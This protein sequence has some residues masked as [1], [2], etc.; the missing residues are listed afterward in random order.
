MIFCFVLFFGSVYFIK[1]I[2]SILGCRLKNLHTVETGVGVVCSH[3]SLG[4]VRVPGGPHLHAKEGRPAHRVDHDD[5]QGH[6]HSLW[7]G[8][9]HLSTLGGLRWAHG[10]GSRG[11]SRVRWQDWNWQQNLC[12]FCVFR[13]L[14]ASCLTNRS[15]IFTFLVFLIF[16]LLYP[17]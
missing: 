8:S 10:A 1:K 14:F 6:P 4:G 13:L 7:H 11:R 12:L 15:W 5:D 16:I 2:L 9:R 3:T 17:I